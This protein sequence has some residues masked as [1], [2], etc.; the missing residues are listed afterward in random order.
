MPNLPPLRDRLVDHFLELMVIIPGRRPNSEEGN[1]SSPERTRHE[2]VPAFAG[3]FA[4]RTV[5]E[6]DGEKYLGRFA[7]A[8]NEVEMMPR[9]HVAEPSSPIGIV[10]SYE[11]RQPNL[12][13]DDVSTGNRSPKCEVEEE[14]PTAE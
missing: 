9:D 11:V 8:Q 14:F 5:V 2:T 4:M 10:A 12:E 13:R 7:V 1:A 6:F 3:K